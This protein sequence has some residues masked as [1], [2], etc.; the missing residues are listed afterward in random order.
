MQVETTFELLDG[1]RPFDRG[2]LDQ[3]RTNASLAEKKTADFLAF[4]ENRMLRVRKDL[5]AVNP[6]LGV[7]FMVGI[8]RDFPRLKALYS[9]QRAYCD[10][11]HELLTFVLEESGPFNV[12]DW[13]I[14]FRQEAD[15]QRYNNLIDKVNEHAAN[16]NTLKTGSVSKN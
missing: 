6:S 1:R 10:A 3:M 16:L 7:E 12:S 15:G 4:F 2:K 13:G 14:S 8:T 11:I 5:V 9:E